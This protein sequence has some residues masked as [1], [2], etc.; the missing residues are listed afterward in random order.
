MSTRAARDANDDDG[1]DDEEDGGAATRVLGGRDFRARRLPPT[2][3]WPPRSRSSATRR[4][5]R[6]GACES[7]LRLCALLA[8]LAL[9]CSVISGE[10]SPAASDELRRGKSAS[11]TRRAGVFACL[12]SDPGDP[13]E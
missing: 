7:I 4:R 13:D 1:N 3:S 8:S 10:F 12:R 11:A 2:M 6:P 9:R 5:S